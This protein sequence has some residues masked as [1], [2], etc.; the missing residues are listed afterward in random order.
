MILNEDFI[1]LYE[2]LSDLNESRADTQKLIDFAGDELASRFFAIKNRLKAP[3]ND[4]YYWIKNKTPEELALALDKLENT[5]S[6]TQLRK[7]A[8]EGGELVCESDHWKVYHITTFEASQYYGRDTKWCITGI[9]NWGDKYWNQYTRRGLQFYFLISKDNYDPR[10]TIS[11]IALAIYPDGKK[12]EVYNQRDAVIP[13]AG[14]PHLDEINIPG[15]SLEDIENPIYCFDCEKPLNNDEIWLGVQNEAY[16]EECFK[17][18][19]FKCAECGRTFYKRYFIE[20]ENENCF[21]HDC[22]S[23][24]DLLNTA[25]QGFYYKLDAPKLNIMGIAINAN[26]TLRRLINY[27]DTITTGDRRLIDV[28]IINNATGEII[29]QSEDLSTITSSK[30]ADDIKKALDAS[31]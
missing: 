1:K 25:T 23:G 8:V 4:L 28:V 30:I 13:L 9:N 27:L 29:Y 6:N 24:F 21:C 12:C 17:Y 15:V 2:E 7:D 19:Y 11:K 3:E 10:G 31:V 5:K 14:I 26:E 16:C 22:D 18:T 20:D